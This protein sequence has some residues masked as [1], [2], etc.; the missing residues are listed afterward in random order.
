[1]YSTLLCDKEEIEN[2]TFF[3]CFFP[4]KAGAKKAITLIWFYSLPLFS[5]ICWHICSSC[6]KVN[7]ANPLQQVLQRDYMDNLFSEGGKLEPLKPALSHLGLYL[8][9]VAFTAMGAKVSKKS[10]FLAQWFLGES[11]NLFSRFRKGWIFA[12]NVFQFMRQK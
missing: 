12:H 4:G 3:L 11:R 7:M 10:I 9:L 8:G 6:W 5:T 2:V 1:M